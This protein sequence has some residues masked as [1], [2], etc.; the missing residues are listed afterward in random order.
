ER[1]S[2]K[3]RTVL[4]RTQ[5]DNSCLIVFFLM[6]CLL[7]LSLKAPPARAQGSTLA[8]RIS[9]LNYGADPT[10]IN[11]STAAFQDAAKAALSVGKCIYV[12]GGTYKLSNA[13]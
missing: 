10:N 6:F 11:D 12:P 8:D 9:V 2:M 4:F 7:L 1:I 13:S 3:R 5:R